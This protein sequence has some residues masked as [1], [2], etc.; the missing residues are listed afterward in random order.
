MQYLEVNNEYRI[1]ISL[2]D[3]LFI[4]FKPFNQQL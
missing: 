4:H 2:I 3:Y 1:I